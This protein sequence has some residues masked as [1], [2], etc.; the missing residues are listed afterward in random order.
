MERKTNPSTPMAGETNDAAASA[1]Q[2]V[3]GV[4]APS[5]LILL[6][7]CS[8]ALAFVRIT[9]AD[10]AT[11]EAA[12]IESAVLLVVSTVA[13]AAAGVLL[14]YR[15]RTAAISTYLDGW[16]SMEQRA[17]DI[18][19]VR[20]EQAKVRMSVDGLSARVAEEVNNLQ[21]REES[22]SSLLSE[23]EKGL[24]E[25]R[26]ARAQADAATRRW[27]SLAMLTAD[28]LFRISDRP[29]VGGL[30]GDLVEQ[31]QGVGLD[32]VRPAASTV[33]DE[34]LHEVSTEEI[35]ETVPAGAVVRTAGIGFRRGERV[36]RRARVVQ[37]TAPATSSL[38]SES[39]ASPDPP[40]KE[41][42]QQADE[43]TESGASDSETGSEQND[44][45]PVM[46]PPPGDTK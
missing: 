13:V 17:S 16:A 34:R 22:L 5:L 23:I 29:G 9:V 18:E 7:L 45:N 30:Y 6:S 8:G 32:V 33:V 35:S 25:S 39:G 19:A 31:L 2:R 12:I 24:I 26:Q 46:I 27:D 42:G 38:D 37:A 41:N 14:N 43:G 28:G 36:L 1:E 20:R 44:S 10:S 3:L 15:Q 11:L 40:L 21:A 4:L